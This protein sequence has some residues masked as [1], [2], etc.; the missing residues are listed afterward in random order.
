M[1][2]TVGADAWQRAHALLLA[3]ERH[4]EQVKV[5][6]A[7]GVATRAELA[8]LQAETEQLREAANELFNAVFRFYEA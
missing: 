2:D 6:H 1:V 7:Q 8:A 4:L 5:R 3:K